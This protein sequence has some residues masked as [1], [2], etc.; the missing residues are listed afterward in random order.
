MVTHY[1]MRCSYA[2]IHDDQGDIF[3]SVV[4]YH[5]VTEQAAARERIEAEVR[6]RTAE[7]AQRNQALN[8]QEQPKIW[9]AHGCSSF[10]NVFLQG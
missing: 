9:P 7:L 2:P 4:L 10:W 6:N 8:W 1:T 5:D 3:A